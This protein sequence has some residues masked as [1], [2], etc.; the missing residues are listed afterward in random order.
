[1]VIKNILENMLRIAETGIH[2]LCVC[3]C[4][5]Q[6]IEI[7]TCKIEVMAEFKIVQGQKKSSM[8]GKVKLKI[9]V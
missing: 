3:V 5:F 1:M 9:Q 7:Y 8:Y 4:L 2:M 6:I